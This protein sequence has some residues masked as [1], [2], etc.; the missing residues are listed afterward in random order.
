MPCVE[1]V[2]ASLVVVSPSNSKFSFVSNFCLIVD[3][4]FHPSRALTRSFKLFT[5]STWMFFC[6]SDSLSINSSP[7]AANLSK[8][9]C[10]YGEKNMVNYLHENLVKSPSV[11]TLCIASVIAPVHAPSIQPICTLCIMSVIAPICAS[12]VPSINP[13]NDERQEFLDGFPGTKYGEKNLSKIMVTFPHDI[14]LT[15]HQ[16]KFPEETPDTTSRVLY[17]GNFMLT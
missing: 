1:A 9:P 14:T 12:P 11:H 6:Y 8:V 3:W 2:L 4:R 7:S 17:P 10:N 15:L 16:A 13:S 5:P